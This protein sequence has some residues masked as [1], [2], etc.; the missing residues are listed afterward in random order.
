MYDAQCR[1][2]DHA[3][4]AVASGRTIYQAILATKY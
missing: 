1:P 2:L 4:E 3:E